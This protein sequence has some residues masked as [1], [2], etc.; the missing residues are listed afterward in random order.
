MVLIMIQNYW[1]KGESISL[2]EKAVKQ[3][4]GKAVSKNTP[5]L[6]FAY[7]PEKTP[8]VFVSELGDLCWEGVRPMEIERTK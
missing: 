1:G 6:V 5:K 4:S 8:Q 2:A 3:Q 7:D